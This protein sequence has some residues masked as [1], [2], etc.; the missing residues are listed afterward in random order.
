MLYRG[1]EPDSIEE[2][3]HWRK[4]LI[5]NDLESAQVCVHMETYCI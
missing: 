5:Y 1:L 3:M 2:E 4:L